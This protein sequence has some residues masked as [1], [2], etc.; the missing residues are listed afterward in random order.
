MKNNPIDLIAEDI[1]S[2][3]QVAQSTGSSLLGSAYEREKHAVAAFLY[4]W[5]NSPH[6][7]RRYQ[8]EIARLWVWAQDQ[9]MLISELSTHDMDRYEDFLRDPQ[10]RERWCSGSRYARS[11][12][13]WRPFVSGLSTDSVKHAFNAIRALL[14]SWLK[15]GY[16]QRDPMALKSPIGAT[17]AD[18]VERPDTAPIESTERWFDQKMAGALRQALL[19][20]PDSEP[21]D[22]V[23]RE[24][25]TLIIRTLTVT[26]ARVSELVGARQ[27]QIYEDRSGWWIKLRGKGGKL[28]SVPL[29]PE[30]VSEVLIP[31]RINRGLSAI[32]RDD[33]ETPLCPP[34]IWTP[35]KSAISSRM[36][37]NIVKDVAAAATA[38]LP[39]EA[40]R[41]IRLLPRASN[42]WF[43]HTFI[44]ALIDSNVPT[45][46]IMT[47]VGQSS[48]KTLRI[49]D[50]KQDHDRHV[51]VTRV[52]STL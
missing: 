35:G 8:T 25:Y 22:K 13:K 34:R 32:P 51:D 27:S 37:L 40:Q 15:S 24:Q 12:E 50:H 30:Y 43:R 5:R 9:Q 47:T 38:L 48:E 18:G 16:I 17:L 44:T 33:E 29:P 31:W 3:K 7:L 23:K 28:R 11:S 2:G 10:P 6:T 46:T 41:A 52:A 42:H 4:R 20:M 36:V 26:G 21:A 45:K 14:T 39:Q 1:I 49:Y 19:S